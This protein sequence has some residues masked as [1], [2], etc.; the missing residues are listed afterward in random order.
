MKPVAVQLSVWGL[1]LLA[2]LCA[3]GTSHPQSNSNTNWLR[4]CSASADCSGDELCACGVCTVACANDDACQSEQAPDAVCASVAELEC[5]GAG[6]GA[7]CTASCKRNKDCGDGALSCVDGSCVKA[8]SETGMPER[9]AAVEPDGDAQMGI[10]DAGSMEP[11]DSGLVGP[12]EPPPPVVSCEE[13]LGC[14]ADSACLNDHCQRLWSGDGCERASEIRATCTTDADCVQGLL[15][16]I[17]GTCIEPGKCDRFGMATLA[18]VGVLGA[19]VATKDSVYVV[20][21]PA[22]DQF[23]NP[24]DEGDIL[25]I[26]IDDGS[27][28]PLV[29]GLFRPGDLL[30][31]SEHMYWLGHGRTFDT[32]YMADRADGANLTELTTGTRVLQWLQNATHLYFV[33]EDDQG[34]HELFRIAKGTTTVEPLTNEDWRFFPAATDIGIDSQYLY[35]RTGAQEGVRWSLT[36]RSLSPSPWPVPAGAYDAENVYVEDGPLQQM[37][38]LRRDDAER[39]VLASHVYDVQWYRLY[40]DRLYIAYQTDHEDI[41]VESVPLTPG[42]PVPVISDIPYDPVPFEISDRGLFWLQ[43]SRDSQNNHV[44]RLV[45]EAFSATP[46]IAQGADGGPCFGDLACDDGLTCVDQRCMVVEPSCEERLG[47][48]VDEA[49]L[50]DR[51][52]PLWSGAGCEPAA[53]GRPSCTTN[54][55]C[56]SGFVC[57]IDG[58]CIEPGKCDRFGLTTLASIDASSGLTLAKDAAFVLEPG[59]EDSHGNHKSDGA[60][61]R[62]GFDGSTESVVTGLYRPLEM[63]LDPD[64]VYWRSGVSGEILLSSADRAGGA[65]RIDI[66]FDG[67]NLSWAQSATHI[68][69]ATDAQPP[70]F[71]LYRLAKGTSTLEKLSDDS[72]SGQVSAMGIDSQYLY[73]SSAPDGRWSIADKTFSQGISLS[74]EFIDRDRFYYVEQQIGARLFR[75]GAFG[76][77]DHKNVVMAEI[78]FVGD[79]SVAMLQPY[80][81]H[82]YFAIEDGGVSTLWRAPIVPGDAEQVV[83]LGSGTFAVA[84]SDRGAFW[85]QDHR[86]LNMVLDDYAAAP[87]PA[88]GA[89]G[90]PCYGD[91][92]CDGALTCVDWLCQ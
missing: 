7:V 49:C 92:A 67:A 75:I 78:P 82:V 27:M 15:C 53:D 37:V 13:R 59:T 22:R 57:H 24:T 77:S 56:D 28:Q 71:D 26:A 55:D 65:N 86:L 44:L 10:E 64:R 74:P 16:H 42:D 51:C 43:P 30:V 21:Y 9:D 35:L 62:V 48:S 89:A 79:S 31:D 25:R 91:L 70:G 80:R 90:G 40:G 2:A 33:G 87:S 52:Q 32:A 34:M 39:T 4:E 68:Y 72:W 88:Q 60:I 85:I 20:D 36:D 11:R 45:S 83:G 54:D 41:A 18:S 50:N 47:C 1:A 61:V 5:S 38:A 6:K 17:D 8:R 14:D 46:A 84:M 3:C 23:G 29:T 73:L 66:P 63:K 19:L 81:D 12:T 76:K 69:V 58:T